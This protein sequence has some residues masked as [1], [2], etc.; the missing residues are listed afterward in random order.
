V[1]KIKFGGTG[2]ILDIQM[3]MQFLKIANMCLIK[4]KFEA[5]QNLYYLAIM[6]GF[7]IIHIC[8]EYLNE[9]KVPST[10]VT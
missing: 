9:I 4:K 2:F 10:F 1:A 7:E 8:Y 6:S 5:F 3:N